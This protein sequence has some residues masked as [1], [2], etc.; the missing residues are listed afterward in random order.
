MKRV[1]ALTVAA[2]IATSG[3]GLA[4]AYQPGT[5][6]SGPQSGFKA[7]GIR[8]EIKEGSFSVGRILMHETCRAPGHRAFHDFGGFQ[9]GSSAS[10][11]G[12][13]SAHGK[14]AGI[15]HDGAGGYT[16]VSGHIRGGHLTVIGA[17]FTA[18][19]TPPHSTVAYSCHA[20]G[21]FHPKRQ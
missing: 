6:K 16:K 21:T 11:T 4:L 7:P 17:E 3:A 14:L 15:F 1:L 10:L 19:Y 9:A 8:V 5:Y 13:I 2:M 12:S 18:S 20:A